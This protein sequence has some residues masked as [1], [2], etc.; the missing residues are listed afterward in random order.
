MTGK[1]A[2]P[3]LFSSIAFFY[4][5]TRKRKCLLT[6][7][8]FI[9]TDFTLPRSDFIIADELTIGSAPRY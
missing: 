6:D 1:N 5:I 8:F 7:Y 2:I 9:L 4:K 3:E